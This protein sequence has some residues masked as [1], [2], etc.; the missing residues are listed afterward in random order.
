MKKIL[1]MM[2][3]LP[4]FVSA[5]TC[6]TVID[7]QTTSNR[8]LVCDAN[9]K[10]TTSFKTNKEEVVLNN[11]VC[12]ITCTEEILFSIDPIKKVL[13]GTSF[14]YPLYASGERKCTA[15]Y[16]YNDYETKIKRLVNEYASLTGTAKTT[17][18]NEITNY[19]AQRKACDEFVKKEGVYKNKYE[20]NG[21][22][23]LKVE[24]S[25]G[26]VTIP[27]KF[28]NI[29]EYSSEVL[30]DS[31]PYYNACNFNETS[32]EC[33]GGDETTAG[34][35]EYARIYGK[36]TMNDTYI[37]KYT[38]EIKDT[39]SNDRCNAGDRYFVNFTELTRPVSGDNTDKGYSLK[40]NANKLGNNIANS[41]NTWN[42]N[43]D[44]WY[45]VK[46]MIFPQTTD[47]LYEKISGTG[48]MYRIIDLNDPFPNRQ[49]GANWVGKES[50]ISS[51]KDRLSTL[52]RFV[53][54]LN[55]SSIDRIR[56][57]NDKYSYEPFVY[58]DPEKE[59]NYLDN[60]FI[61]YFNGVIDRKTN[62]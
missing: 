55:T 39:S 60:Y 45:Q 53:I 3:L 57:Y 14:S 47:E 8:N 34:W 43:V 27:Y 59:D 5:E 23:E 50:V 42:L 61:Q 31:T 9:N 26:G 6:N 35:T 62:K 24:T 12:S 58:E 36:Y 54:N 16:N 15:T 29:D 38:G 30:S 33:A 17:K 40:L 52:Q 20:F 37:E 48:F 44:C 18:G 32:K 11:S 10:T 4:I 25:E 1:V 28:V 22:V 19:Y 46:N 7:K 13:A 21:D 51:T 41:G 49:P 2:M 56:D